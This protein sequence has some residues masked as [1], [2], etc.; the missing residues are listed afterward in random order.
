MTDLTI[1]QQLSELRRRARMSLG[2]VA[3]AAGY[4]GPSSVQAMFRSE[5]DPKW[6]PV[7]TATRLVPVFE[8]KGDPPITMG[9][10]MK[11]CGLHDSIELKRVEVPDASLRARSRDIPVYGTALAADIP[12]DENGDAHSVEQTVFEMGDTIA[13]APRPQGISATSKVYALFVAGSSMEP[14]YR[15]GDP[16]FVD[17]HRPPSI[18]DDVIVQLSSVGTEEPEIIA[19]LIKTLV[20]RTGSFLELEQ[21]SPAIRFRVPMDRVARMHRVIPLSEL[22]GI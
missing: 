1:G 11:L 3:Q 2:E 19:G 9:E 13:Y 8:G 6:L 15:P 4:A 21:Y 16:L 17:P 20:K 10:I 12:F 18:G 7:T 5:Y 14:R 22:F